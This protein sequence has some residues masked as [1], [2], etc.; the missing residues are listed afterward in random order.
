MLIFG[1]VCNSEG[2]PDGAMSGLLRLSIKDPKRLFEDSE[3]GA[4]V[5]GKFRRR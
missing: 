1:L 3:N 2:F 4:L 5:A